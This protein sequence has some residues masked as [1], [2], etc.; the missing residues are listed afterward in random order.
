V[1]EI[2]FCTLYVVAERCILCCMLRFVHAKTHFSDTLEICTSNNC[3]S[4]VLYASRIV[5]LTEAYPDLLLRGAE[6]PAVFSQ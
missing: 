6:G 4:G 2:E 5:I 1:S 3:A